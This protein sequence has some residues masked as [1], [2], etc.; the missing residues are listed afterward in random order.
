MFQ[1]IRIAA[2]WLTRQLLPARLPAQGTHRIT[3]APA[4][5]ERALP[6]RRPHPYAWDD[7]GP[8]LRPY[9]LNAEEWARRRGEL[10]PGTVGAAP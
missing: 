9:V 4:G 8:L 6:V 5:T 2:V 7:D 10:A 3:A 1:L